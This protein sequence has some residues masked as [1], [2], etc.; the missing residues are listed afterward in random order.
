MTRAWQHAGAPRVLMSLWD[1]DDEATRRLMT[2]TVQL[3]QDMPADQ[4]LRQVMIESRQTSPH[5]AFWAG[6]T[7]FGTP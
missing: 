1:V 2:R 4:A 6:F 3:A 7:L 5:Q